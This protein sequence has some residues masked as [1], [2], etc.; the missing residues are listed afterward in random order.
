VGIS[1]AK[2]GNVD[3]TKE[4]G[5]VLSKIRIGLGWDLRKTG[6]DAFDLDA[7]VVG[8]TDAGVSAGTDW[9]VFYNRLASPG[10]AI[11]HQGDELTGAA[12]GDDEQI[13]IDFSLLPDHIAELVVAVTIH[14]AGTRGQNFGMVDNAYVRVVNEDGGAELA[15]YDLSEDGS[16]LN[17]VVMGKAY[18]KDGGWKFKALG[19]GFAT[20]MQGIID[21]YKIA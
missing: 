9:F 12:E 5:G 20:E 1:L 11:V 17:T 6:G 4:A 10:N 18:R 21:A 15:R 7:S 16:G 2:G 13:V 8:L 3:L 19:D 14:E